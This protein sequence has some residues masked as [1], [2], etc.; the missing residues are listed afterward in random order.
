MILLDTDVCIELLR[1][2]KK[3]IQKRK[4]ED[5][6]IAISFMTL[7]ELFYGAEKSSNPIKNRILVEEF[8]LTVSIIQSDY[9]IMRKYAE[10]KANLETKG[11]PLTDA[12]LFI[13]ATTLTKCNKMITGNIKHYNRIDELRIENWIR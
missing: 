11:V 8:V 5:D 7:A 6:S 13:A 2:N 4:E 9:S 10:L 12:D 3:V 1:G